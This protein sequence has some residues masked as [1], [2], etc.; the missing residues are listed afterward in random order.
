MTNN[1]PIFHWSGRIRTIFDASPQTTK[2]RNFLHKK[3]EMSF[4]FTKWVVERIKG[5]NGDRFDQMYLFETAF[6]VCTIIQR[7]VI[8]MWVE[9]LLLLLLLLSL[10]TA[11]QNKTKQ[12]Q[13]ESGIRRVKKCFNLV[14]ETVSC[15]FCVLL[16]FLLLLFMAG[17]FFAQPIPNSVCV[18]I[19]KQVKTLDFDS[20]RSS[21]SGSGR[22]GENL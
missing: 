15:L 22:K 20:F 7:L 8:S 5:K 4:T 2:K 21:D 12:T 19:Q 10:E 18:S 14:D 16:F 3:F 9:S 17:H 1:F 13:G 6:I 11:K